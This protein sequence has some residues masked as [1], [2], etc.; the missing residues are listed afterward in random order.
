MN[1]PST[2]EELGYVLCKAGP[3]RVAFFAQ[4]VVSVEAWAEG[5]VEAAH[6]RE[7]FVLM[8]AQGRLLRA[9]EGDGIVV[10]TVEVLSDFP[11]LLSAPALVRGQVGGAVGGF[12]VTSEGLWPVLNLHDFAQFLGWSSK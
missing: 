1:G 9:R 4:H 7:A 3:H 2:E 12:L 5:G 10:D 8:R 6:A 11:R